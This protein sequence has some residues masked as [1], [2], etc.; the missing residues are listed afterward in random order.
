MSTDSPSNAK[1]STSPPRSRVSDERT[2][3]ALPCTIDFQGMAP[4]HVYFRPVEAEDGV[5]NATLRGRGLLALKDD[6]IKGS[7]LS[8]ESD[9]V[10]VKAEIDH[11]LEW[12]HE[13]HPETLQFEGGA[14][15][16]NQAQEWLEVAQAVSLW[17]LRALCSIVVKGRASTNN[18]R[19][20]CSCTIRFLLMISQQLFEYLCE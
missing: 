15:R 16:V 8:I 20:L 18:L 19:L 3:H 14:G 10:Q 1:T 5:C 12:K 17:S 7:L 4:T 2:C 9:R 6:A 11:I 13:H